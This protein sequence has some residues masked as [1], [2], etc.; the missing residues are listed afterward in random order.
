MATYYVFVGSKSKAISYTDLPF[1]TLMG[2]P[3][4]AG[5]EQA[6]PQTAAVKTT[7]G[8]SFSV[9]YDG[10]PQFKPI[11]GTGMTYAVNTSAAVIWSGGRYY[12]CD[13][14]VWYESA[15]ATGVSGGGPW[16]RR[17]R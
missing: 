1:L 8:A 10:K 11:E 4:A 5:D 14:G 13:Q 7:A 6:V 12:A 2:A 17:I 9:T 16:M 15:A 3:A